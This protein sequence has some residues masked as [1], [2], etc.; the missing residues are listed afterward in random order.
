MGSQEDKRAKIIAAQQAREAADRAAGR[1]PATPE[2]KSNWAAST[3][4]PGRR[5]PGRPRTMRP[6]TRDG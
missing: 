3:N 6:G 2:R 5:G 4:K 1:V